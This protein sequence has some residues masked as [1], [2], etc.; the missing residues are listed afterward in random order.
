MTACLPCLVGSP[1]TRERCNR[2][3]FPP[4]LAVVYPHPCCRVAVHAPARPRAQAP[5]STATMETRST[6]DELLALSSLLA[7]PSSKPARAGQ[8]ISP[9]RFPRVD[10]VTFQGGEPGGV[11]RRQAPRTAATTTTTMPAKYW[12]AE[13]GALDDEVHD[14]YEGRS[15]YHASACRAG[16]TPTPLPSSSSRRPFWCPGNA[17][18]PRPASL[19]PAVHSAPRQR[20]HLCGERVRVSGRRACADPLRAGGSPFCHARHARRRRRRC[21]GPPDRPQLGAA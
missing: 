14:E 18:P 11:M 19:R 4:P 7:S 17:L 15:E 10:E 2:R 12:P 3:C 16:A 6:E 20:Y 13:R 21:G 5:N 9:Q 1:H 8:A